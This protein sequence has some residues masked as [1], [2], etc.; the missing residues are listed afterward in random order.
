MIASSLRLT[1]AAEDGLVGL[2]VAVTALPRSEQLVHLVLYFLDLDG[3][4]GG[5][6][7][8]ADDGEA[9]GGIGLAGRVGEQHVDHEVAEGRWLFLPLRVLVI[10]GLS[11]DVDR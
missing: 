4:D 7:E 2:L 8:L 1:D 3:L 5:E 6:L 10:L 11:S 9:L